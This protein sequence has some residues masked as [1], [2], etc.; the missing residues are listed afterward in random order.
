MLKI[1]LDGTNFHI[2]WTW[3]TA[4]YLKLS[5]E[6]KTSYHVNGGVRSHGVSW[7]DIERQ[8]EKSQHVHQGGQRTMEAG[9]G[10]MLGS[11]SWQG[12]S[13]MGRGYELIVQRWQMFLS[14]S[15]QK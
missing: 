7:R 14:M 15:W 11:P 9:E 2:K 13:G 1:L 10:K 6:H 12:V 3:V 5:L 8:D 4:E